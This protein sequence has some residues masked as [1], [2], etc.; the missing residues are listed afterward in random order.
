MPVSVCGERDC[1]NNISIRSNCICCC[2]CDKQFHV[3]C[4]HISTKE[5]VSLVEKGIGFYCPPCREELFAFNNIETAEELE[6]L[7]NNDIFIDSR[8][9]KKCKCGGCRKKIDKN[10]PAAHCCSCSNYYH[11]KCEKLCK[12][13]F[14]LAANWYC[15]L[16]TLKILPFFSIGNE[17]MNLLNQDS[18]DVL[19]D[20]LEV[21]SPSFSIRSLLDKMPETDQFMSD[22]ILS[23]YYTICEFASSKFSKQK[24]SIFHLNIASLQKHI[25]ELRS[26]LS[27]A[28]HIFDII[29]ISE[30]RIKD[31]LSLANVQLDGYDFVHTPSSTQCGG[32]G[33]YIRNGIAFEIIKD[34]TRSHENICESIF[35]ELKHPNRKNIIIGCIY[36]HHSLVKSFLDTYVRKAIQT[37]T[38]SKH[39]CFLAGDFNVDLIKYGDTGCNDEFYDELSCHGFRLLILQPTRV[40][41]KSFTLIDNI[42][43]NDITSHSSGG[44]L[45]TSI[46]DHFSQFSQID[47]FEKIRPKNRIKYGRNWRLFNKN[48]FKDELGK[49]TWE[50]VCSP[51]I[52]TDTGVSNFYH[53]IEKLLDEMAPVKRLNKKEVGLQQR[54]WIIPDILCAMSERDKLY[55][56]FRLENDLS[57]R[58]VK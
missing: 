56:V 42:F 50:D 13:D 40:T 27:C 45:T 3:K 43:T 5:F 23:K 49:C 26:L 52:D 11:L 9:E 58:E 31:E 14:P 24:F 2:I 36:R 12:K 28:H 19:I 44:N 25:H 39:T 47:V 53:K 51:N 54:P 1:R 46:S 34:L 21:N 33:I 41:S 35:V 29:C 7:F 32:V 55:K 22:T 15:S 48:E 57:L 30:T 20:N 4:A 37:T 6:K 38:K 18:D 10:M 17:N 16:C 8:I